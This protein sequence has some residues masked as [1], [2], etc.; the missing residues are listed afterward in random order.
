MKY[1]RSLRPV[2]VLLASPV[3][4]A[5]LA[6]CATGRASHALAADPT[7]GPAVSAPSSGATASAAKP[8][9]T[10][11][12][13]PSNSGLRPFAE[14]V[15]D[16]RHIE[17][18]FSLWQ[19]DDK[20]WIELMPSDLDHPFFMSP[21][22]KAGMGEGRFYGGLMGEEVVIEF[23]R[24]HNQLQMLARNTEFVAKA[25]TP[26]GRAVDVAFSP[27]LLAST[28]ILSQP[29]P[30]RQSILV[31]ANATYTALPHSNA[32]IGRSSS[33]RRLRLASP[34]SSPKLNPRLSSSNSA[35]W[36]RL[37]NCPKLRLPIGNPGNR[38]PG[39]CCQC[40][41]TIPKS[42]LNTAIPIMTN[43][44]RRRRLSLET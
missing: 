22:I 12:A 19:K 15:K 34:A 5:L 28:S 32:V 38:N 21:K 23:R 1:F 13:N 40:C 33:R 25:D 8:A 20:V 2:H 9:A 39:D 11:H 10:A 31:E 6:G 37:I 44:S 35:K 27:S 36:F 30:E 29:H 41:R 24:V 18:L 43:T 42:A 16:A 7:A 3:L 17:G 14:I 4:V 26:A